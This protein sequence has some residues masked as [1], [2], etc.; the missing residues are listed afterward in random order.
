PAAAEGRGGRV[1]ALKDTDAP[2]P[3]AASGKVGDTSFKVDGTITNVAQLSALDLAV[4]VSGRT[5]AELY[6]VIGVALPGTSKY[7]TRGRLVRAQKM[8][9]YQN[10]TGRVGDSDIA[11]TLQFDTGGKRVFM[12]GELNSKLLNL[13]DLGPLVGPD[14]P[15]DEGVLPDMPFDSDRW[16]SIDADVKIRAGS[17]RRPKALPLENLATRIQMKDKVLT[18]DPFEVGIAGGRIAGPIKLDGQKDPIAAQ[19]ALRVRD[20]SLPK[21]F[22]TLKE[23]QKSIGDI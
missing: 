22:P 10:F 2:Y 5:M 18:L 15:K 4:Q 19:A 12:H 6:D 3:L 13:A 14:Q 21:L 11:G 1:L 17:I 7:T 9:R 23:N 20:L 8:I 16:D